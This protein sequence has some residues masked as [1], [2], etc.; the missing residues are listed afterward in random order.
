[1]K[2]KDI[3][4]F[5]ESYRELLQA[6]LRLN[7]E[8]I[9]ASGGEQQALFNAGCVKAYTLAIRELNSIILSLTTNKKLSPLL[10]IYVSEKEK[11]KRGK[12]A[13]QQ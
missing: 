3:L 13:W 7:E 6:R 1:M 12:R 9:S 8:V 11:L 2:K 4:T 10:E 5:L